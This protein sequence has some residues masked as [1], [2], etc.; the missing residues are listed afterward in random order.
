MKRSLLL[1]ILLL[2]HTLFPEG[3]AAGTLVRTLSGYTPI[4]QIKEFDWILCYDSNKDTL[5]YS[6]VM[7]TLT[8]Q[9]EE[10]IHITIGDESFFVAPDQQFCTATMKWIKAFQL[11]SGVALHGQNDLLIDIDNVEIIHE[12]VHLYDFVLEHYG[13]FFI[14]KKNILVHDYEV[15][16]VIIS[17]EGGGALAAFLGLTGTS[18]AVFTG[19]ISLSV[20]LGTGW[21]LNKYVFKKTG[22]GAGNQNRDNQ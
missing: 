19:G 2:N 8:R 13:T 17:A 1:F 6:R 10:V 9:V 12:T 11:F 21:L 7:Q 15:A 14:S 16:P 18:A 22:G 4:E 5:Q 20:V 3:F